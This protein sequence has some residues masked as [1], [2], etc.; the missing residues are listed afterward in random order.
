MK[1]IIRMLALVFVVSVL[2]GCFSAFAKGI[3]YPCGHSYAESYS[4]NKSA[5]GRTSNSQGGTTLTAYVTGTYKLGTSSTIYSFSG[6]RASGVGVATSS[7]NYQGASTI[8]YNT[9]YN[10]WYCYC[11]SCGEFYG[12][13]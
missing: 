2:I 13:V 9:I 4:S 11:L 10:D 3:M 5:I 1:K 8:T 6:S 12:Q 7:Y